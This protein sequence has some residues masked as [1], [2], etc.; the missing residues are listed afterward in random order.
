MQARDVDWTQIVPVVIERRK[1][2]KPWNDIAAELG[3]QSEMLRVQMQTEYD[4]H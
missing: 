1:E 3:I 4:I 2:R